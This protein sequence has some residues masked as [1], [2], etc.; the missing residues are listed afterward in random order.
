VSKFKDFGSTLPGV[1]SE[2]ISF[3]IYDEEFH[4]TPALQGKV[5]LGF[6]ADSTSKDPAVQASVI[7]RFFK[8]V[9]TEESLERFDALQDT[10]DKIVSVDT[11]GEIVAWVVEQYTNRPEEQPEA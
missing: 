8:Y 2:P 6:V 3:K 4:C 11:L 1:Q 5:L 10:R 7:E 9:L